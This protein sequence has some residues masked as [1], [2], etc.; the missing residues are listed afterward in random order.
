MQAKCTHLLSAISGAVHQGDSNILV[1]LVERH[2]NSRNSDEAKNAGFNLEELLA[3]LPRRQHE[4]FAAG[5]LRQCEDGLLRI[6]RE[7]GKDGGGGGIEKDGDVDMDGESDWDGDVMI[8]E[9]VG[10]IVGMLLK[11][12]KSPTTESLVD[13]VLMLHGC[14]KTVQGARL[15]NM[16][17]RICEMFWVEDRPKKSMLVPEMMLYLL[18]RALGDENVE[19]R[20]N[21]DGDDRKE[22]RGGPKKGKIGGTVADLKRLLSV[23]DA[24][25]CLDVSS[26]DERDG[27]FNARGYILRCCTSGLFLKASE[28]QKF[29]AHALT[30]PDISSAI[31]S[32]MLS[33]LAHIRKSRAVS[34]GNVYFYAWKSQCMRPSALASPSEEEALHRPTAKSNRITSILEDLCHKA[35]HAATE[36]LATN[37]RTI[38]SSFHCNKRVRGVDSMLQKLYSPLLFRSLSVANS[39]VR[40]N[41]LY[42]LADA[43]PIHSPENALPDIQADLDRQFSFLQDLLMDPAPMVRVAAVSASARVC[44]LLWELIP[45]HTAKRCAEILTQLASDAASSAVRAEVCVGLRFMFENHFTHNI[46][47]VVLPS[48]NY[49]IEDS[50]ERVR[51]SFLDL[52]ITVR[53]KRVKSCKY[54]DIVNLEELLR[55]LPR[56]SP[57]CVSKLLDLLAPTYFPLTRKHKSEKDLDGIRLRAC[58]SLIKTNPEAAK[59][60]YANLYLHVSPGPLCRLAKHLARET[61]TWAENAANSSNKPQAQRKTKSKHHQ[62]S[63]NDLSEREQDDGEEEVLDLVEG[64]LDQEIVTK[65][66]ICALVLSSVSS[67]LKKDSNASLLAFTMKFLETESFLALIEEE[68]PLSIRISAWKIVSSV[69]SSS[70]LSEPCKHL[71]LSALKA[72]PKCLD[73]MELIEGIVKIAFHWGDFDKLGAVV[74]DW[75][76]GNLNIQAEPP[77]KKTKKSSKKNARTNTELL[78]KGKEGIKAL[79]KSI[80]TVAQQV[81]FMNVWEAEEAKSLLCTLRSMIVEEFDANANENDVEWLVSVAQ[82]IAVAQAEQEFAYLLRWAGTQSIGPRTKGVRT[83]IMR[84][85][86]DLVALG[87]LEEATERFVMDVQGDEEYE[88][89]LKFWSDALRAAYFVICKTENIVGGSVD[90]AGN[91]AE[92]SSNLLSIVTQG[93]FSCDV[94]SESDTKEIATIIAIFADILTFALSSD[95]FKE[96]GV[97][98]GDDRQIESILP[99]VCDALQVVFSDE[100]AIEEKNTFSVVVISS[101]VQRDSKLMGRLIKTLGATWSH[102]RNVGF[103]NFCEAIV[104]EVD[105]LD[106]PATASQVR[107]LCSEYLEEPGQFR[108]VNDASVPILPI[109]EPNKVAVEAT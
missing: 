2:R 54:F 8:V 66:S 37:L 75:H 26:H 30:L 12:K 43:F 9:A 96:A 93:L 31:H 90:D 62:D 36:P 103:R 68:L 7:E 108:T 88:A 98:T 39:F 52:L 20:A 32:S 73:N 33:T 79:T 3:F 5:V 84:V 23:K 1:N 104:E 89:S 65:F 11:D 41:A 50:S 47:S 78:Q 19:A 74:E 61:Y 72:V 21:Q 56:E 44:G 76:E 55:R 35:V 105:K 24:L 57:A 48:L 46:L 16:I 49:L 40:R 81:S 106:D 100:A 70:V 38:L 77:L 67:S 29:L 17:S 53:D 64:D 92:K 109:I 28:G 86:A 58:S 15:K 18:R 45:G 85:G 60:F 101:I 51:L 6:G 27:Q 13:V 22:R 94:A 14:L 80:L 82:L 42:I 10:V 95:M 102:K 34:Y 91:V 59:E 71:W 69:P 99:I 97:L 87:M 107:Q 25:S 83:V 4:E 63:E